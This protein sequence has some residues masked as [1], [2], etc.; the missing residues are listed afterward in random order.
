MA[1]YS[2]STNSFAW[3]TSGGGTGDDQGNG[4]AVSG[5]TVYVTG[6]FT[7]GASANISGTSLAGAGNLDIFVAKYVDS[8]TTF[9][10]RGAISEGGN[11]G[12]DK[13]IA[14]AVSGSTVYVT[15][16]MYAAAGG[17]VSIS[18]T[19]LTDNGIADFFLARYTDPGS[20]TNGFTNGGAV[21][22][23]GS[24]ADAGN[25]IAVNGTK[26][27][28]AGKYN[29]NSTTPVV[30]AG[31]TLP[32][33]SGTNGQDFFVAK[34]TDNGSGFTGGGPCAAAVQCRTMPTVLP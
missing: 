3:A 5:S 28:V 13:G 1:K 15:G 31:T 18:G 24:I 20:T 16:Q 10:A 7:S 23:G 22:G 25:A 2:A 30:I 21:S 9:T 32:S 6:Q 27:Y 11:A 33:G 19:T 14:I 29:S 17:T 34:Y 4:I 8:G 26:V 12:I